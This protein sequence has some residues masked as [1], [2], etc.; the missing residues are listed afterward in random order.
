MP[1]QVF[2]AN[3]ERYDSWFEDHRASYREELQER[4]F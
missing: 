1:Y 2:D 3:A 4:N